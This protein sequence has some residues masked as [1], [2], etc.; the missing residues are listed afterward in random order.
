MFSSRLLLAPCERN[1]VIGWAWC[2]T[3]Q[4]IGACYRFYREQCWLADICFD[5]THCTECCG[6]AGE[7]ARAAI[8]CDVHRLAYVVRQ[9]CLCKLLCSALHC[10]FINLP[11][12]VRLA[13][14]RPDS[15]L[16]AG[17]SVSSGDLLHAFVSSVCLTP[18]CICWLCVL[19][20]CISGCQVF[21]KPNA[22]LCVPSSPHVGLF[23]D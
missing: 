12:N 15:W 23:L 3:Q 4:Y 17:F 9:W 5:D 6:V 22:V 2:D 16:A 21:C 7:K 13:H 18:T 20:L 14:R 19:W 1:C 11:S 10:V 8:L